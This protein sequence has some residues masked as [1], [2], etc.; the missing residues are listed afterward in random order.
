MS[1]GTLNIV[2]GWTLSETDIEKRKFKNYCSTTFAYIFSFTCFVIHLHIWISF[3]LF[4]L[5]FNTSSTAKIK[6]FVRILIYT[7][8]KAFYTTV[9]ILLDNSFYLGITRDIFKYINYVNKYL[10]CKKGRLASTILCI[11]YITCTIIAI[12][13]FKKDNFRLKLKYK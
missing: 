2:K 12:L 11:V 4:N 10:T 5:G 7:K 9:I 13:V 8:L 6:K 1:Y 3:R